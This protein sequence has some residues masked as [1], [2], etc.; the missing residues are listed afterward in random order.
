MIKI[1][2]W[3]SDDIVAFYYS[4]IGSKI[5][6]ALKDD[7]I[8]YLHFG[9][10]KHTINLFDLLTMPLS[11]IKKQYEGIGLYMYL[12][13][14]RNYKDKP[15]KEILKMLSECNSSVKKIDDNH[16]SIK[17]IREL[18][19]VTFNKNNTVADNRLRYIRKY[20][21]ERIGDFNVDVYNEIVS[22]HSNYATNTSNWNEIID[23]IIDSIDRCLAPNGLIIH[24]KK[25]APYA[26]QTYVIH[27]R[28]MNHELRS[29]LIS[30]LGLTTCPYCNRQYITNI[31][32]DEI[33]NINT[34]NKEIIATADLDHFYPK[35]V[36]PLF[37]LSLFNYIPSCQI[38]NSK[39]KHSSS[40]CILYPYEEGFEDKV[41]FKLAVKDTK[42]NN[43]LLKYWMGLLDPDF[44][45]LQL[46]FNH[47][48]NIDD[49]YVLRAKGSIEM[50]H[51][52]NAYQCHISKAIDTVLKK[53]IFFEGAYEN[54]IRD[55]LSRIEIPYSDSLLK[56]MI[57]GYDW[58]TDEFDEPLSKFIYDIFN[59]E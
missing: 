37:A 45:Y 22:N 40:R 15:G 25:R 59:Y 43:E 41:L 2:R 4:D 50:F 28:L 31:S 30:S 56:R 53:R 5:Q 34:E 48:Y 52:R 51:L 39:F 29:R 44:F 7:E 49:D 6:S 36:Y 21:I 32:E 17:D 58:D 42:D 47:N 55:F 11:E 19:N 20:I 10:V 46:V 14:L 23:Y 1:K 38:C 57:L 24:N 27:Y 54:C 26:E 13:E 16:Y 3:Y 8:T 18:S 33:G 12:C 35:S 9:N